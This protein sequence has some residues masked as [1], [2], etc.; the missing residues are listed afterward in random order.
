MQCAEGS[1]CYVAMHPKR[2]AGGRLCGWMIYGERF[3]RIVCLKCLS[4]FSFSAIIIL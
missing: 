3:L 1:C 2:A 4:R